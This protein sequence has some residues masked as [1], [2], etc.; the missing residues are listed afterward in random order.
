MFVSYQ[1][2]SFFHKLLPILVCF[3]LIPAILTG[4]AYDAMS[5]NVL[6]QQAREEL[7]DIGSQMTVLFADMLAEYGEILENISLSTAV[8]QYLGDGK[9]FKSET[10]QLLQQHMFSR[11]NQIAIHLIPYYPLY[12]TISS[13][14]VP[15]IY[16]YQVYKN[17]GIFARLKVE[18]DTSVLHINHYRSHTGVSVSLSLACN[19]S[20]VQAFW[21]RQWPSVYTRKRKGC[22]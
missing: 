14:S 3:A 1:K 10:V 6:M 11:I 17:W 4:V 15:N 8:R 2:R 5:R 13:G 19:D 20:P 18:A 22:R 21:R 12:E 7:S 16:R 9:T